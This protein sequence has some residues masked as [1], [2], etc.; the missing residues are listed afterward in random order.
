MEIFFFKKNKLPKAS[1][2]PPDTARG[3]LLSFNAAAAK[4]SGW[5]WVLLLAQAGPEGLGGFWEQ[6]D[7]LSYFPITYKILIEW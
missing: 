2:P 7:T 4:T 6:L 3:P 1:L 5:H